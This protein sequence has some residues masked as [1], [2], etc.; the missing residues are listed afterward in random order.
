MD[1]RLLA[2]IFM[3]AFL[4]EVS[5]TV[6]RQ[7]AVATPDLYDLLNLEIS[8]DLCAAVGMDGIITNNCKCQN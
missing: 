5:G 3:T 7:N 8:I 6:F 1:A 2:T 4:L